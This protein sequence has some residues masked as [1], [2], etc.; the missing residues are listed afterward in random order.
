MATDG[1][2]A[3]EKRTLSNLRPDVTEPW[4]PLVA[5]FTADQKLPVVVPTKE[6]D[7]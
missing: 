5:V 3:F 4:V 2:T 1:R 6:L 7:L